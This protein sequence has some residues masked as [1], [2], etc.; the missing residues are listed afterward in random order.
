MTNTS[1]IPF[2]IN[3]YN[4]DPNNVKKLPPQI[5]SSVVEEEAYYEL[6]NS[7]VT[8]K[9]PIELKDEK[10]T[11]DDPLWLQEIKLFEA[12]RIT[13]WG[14][15][16]F[17]INQLNALLNEDYLRK[18]AKELYE[19]K[20]YD[21]DGSREHFNLQEG[22]LYGFEEYTSLMQRWLEDNYV[23]V[24]DIRLR[25]DYFHSLNIKGTPLL[26]FKAKKVEPYVSYRGYKSK[27]ITL[28]RVNELEFNDL[29]W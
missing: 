19:D 2:V 24:S 8:L 27:L 14:R 6:S 18:K 10:A 22:K 20:L 3:S 16:P 21:T 4:I 13:D 15:N 11:P 17:D 12:T 26:I 29:F 25:D 7:S 1:N 9:Q 23:A 5:L 28:H